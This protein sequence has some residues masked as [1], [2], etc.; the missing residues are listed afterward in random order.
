MFSSRRVGPGV[1]SRLRPDG[2]RH[3]AASWA[4]SAGVALLS[5]F[6]LA[7]PHGRA[8]EADPGPYRMIASVSGG[9]ADGLWDYATIDGPA[10]RLYLAQDGVTV[11]DL[12]TGKVTPHFVIGRTFRGLGMSH[13]AMSVNNGRTLAVSDAGANS[14][15]FFDARTGRLVSEV[16]LGPVVEKNWRNPDSLL[17]EPAS[18]LLI[19]V[20]GDSGNLSLIDTKA[21]A[22]RGE[23]RV[24]KGRLETAAADGAG[25]VYVNEEETGQIAVVDVAK[26]RVV[27]EFPMRDCTEPTGL[28]YDSTDQMVIS[29]CSNGFVKLIGVDGGEEIASIKVGAGADGLVFDPMRHALFSF[30]GEDGTLSVITVHG[31][32]HIALAQTLKT[33]PGGRLGALDPKTGRIYIPVASFG[34]P[35]APMRLP[36]LGEIPG[37]NPGTFEFLVAAPSSP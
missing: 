27:A 37:L 4:S 33:R 9:E 26:R 28:V 8:A 10:R 21:F 18:K 22:K 13:Q 30:G 15:D 17:Y 5:A 34:P 25:R 7:A 19:A 6:S 11:L 2:G 36:G 32:R 1:T 31:R 20:S 14:V 35:A 16:T 3:R 12:D 24:G 29:A 23:I